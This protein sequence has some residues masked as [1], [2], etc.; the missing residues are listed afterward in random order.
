M[1]ERTTRTPGLV[2]VGQLATQIRHVREAA[3]DRTLTIQVQTPKSSILLE[4]KPSFQEHLEHVQELEAAGVD[5]FVVHAAGNTVGEVVESLQRYAG[6][7][8]LSA[9]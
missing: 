7:V 9:S 6:H 3:E 5:S 4:E 2:S 1:R 8:D